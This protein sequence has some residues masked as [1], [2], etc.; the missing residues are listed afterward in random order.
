VLLDID[1][2][3]HSHFHNSLAYNDLFLR[4]DLIYSLLAQPLPLDYSLTGGTVELLLLR[5]LS[6]AAGGAAVQIERECK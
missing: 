2:E 3:Q 6:I 4:D 5:K 1:E